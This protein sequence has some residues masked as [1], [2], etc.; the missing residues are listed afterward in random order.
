MPILVA[1]VIVV[2]TTTALL[3]FSSGMQMFIGSQKTLLNIAERDA[4]HFH[5]DCR[6]ANRGR[7]AE[8]CHLHHVNLKQPRTKIYHYTWQQEQPLHSHAAP[9]CRPRLSDERRKL[10]TLDTSAKPTPP[11]RNP[12]QKKKSSGAQLFTGVKTS[13]SSWLGRGAAET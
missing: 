11:S 4:L 5:L 3:V 6:V 13:P 12:P 1:K 2:H 9:K 7:Q 10:G 8:A